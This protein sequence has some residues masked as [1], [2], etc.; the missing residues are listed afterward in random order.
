[1]SSTRRPSRTTFA[2]SSTL[3]GLLVFCT[4]ITG[5]RAQF[6]YSEDFKNSTAVGWVLSPAGNSTPN[7]VLTSG[8]APRTGDP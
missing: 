2:V 8:A 7:V 4:V 3:L 6:T 5:A 1:M